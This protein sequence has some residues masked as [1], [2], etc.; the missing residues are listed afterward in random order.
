M[1]SFLLVTGRKGLGFGLFWRYLST[2][3][4]YCTYSSS[5]SSSNRRIDG[6]FSLGDWASVRELPRLAIMVLFLFLSSLLW[7]SS[8][9]TL[10]MTMLGAP[11]LLA[12][13][14]LV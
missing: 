2:E 10:S 6:D 13:P 7:A 5:V 3:F 8:T 1:A 14:R 12:R 4:M 9:S 11:A